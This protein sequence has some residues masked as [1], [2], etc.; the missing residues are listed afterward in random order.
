VANETPSA[1]YYKVTSTTTG[2]RTTDWYGQFQGVVAGATGLKVTYEGNDSAGSAT[3]TLY[4]WRWTAP[5]GWVQIGSPA[6][7]GPADVT[8]GPFAACG[9]GP[10]PSCSQ[11]V[12]TGANKGRVRVRVLST[13]PATNFVTGGDLM[14]LVYDAP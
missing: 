6:S 14:K 7:V 1:K 12:G 8:V 4:V 13:Q 2:T 3:Q 9:V 11:V 5:A 10:L